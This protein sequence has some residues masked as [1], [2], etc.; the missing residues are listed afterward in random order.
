MLVAEQ[1]ETQVED[2]VVSPYSRLM[3]AIAFDLDT[4]DL[5]VNYPGPSS[6]NGYKEIRDILAGYGFDWQQGSVYY[7]DENVTSVTTILAA[8]ALSKQL[9]WFKASV[10]D[11]RILQLLANDDLKPAL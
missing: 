11:I 7:G 2:P 6:N 3:Y 9:P 8:Q 1:I 4:A 10:K 5:K